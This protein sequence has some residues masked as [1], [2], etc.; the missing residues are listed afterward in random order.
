MLAENVQRLADC[1]CHDVP[2]VMIQNQTNLTS[3][4]PVD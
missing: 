4:H 1:I 3:I 2:A